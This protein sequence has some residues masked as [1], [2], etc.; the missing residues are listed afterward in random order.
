MKLIEQIVPE[1]GKKI[2]HTPEQKDVPFEQTIK[3]D[4]KIP[5]KI[6]IVTEGQFSRLINENVGEDTT[7]K[8]ESISGYLSDRKELAKKMGELMEKN[9][10]NSIT[11][12]TEI[13][14][15]EWVSIVDNENPDLFNSYIEE[16]E[17][18]E[19]GEVEFKK[20]VHD[21]D[22]ILINGKE[23]IVDMSNLDNYRFINDYERELQ[24]EAIK[25]YNKYYTPSP[26]EEGIEYDNM[27]G[28]RKFGSDYHQNSGGGYEDDRNLDESIKRNFKRF[29]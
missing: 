29:I 1:P 12:N 15:S 2:V 21:G 20:I 26:S 5:K 24:P 16:L 23:Y 27:D 25:F 18:S 22:T 9:N 11:I 8:E 28:N 19:N 6:I 10:V 4:T 13:P 3:S 17:T 14:A 7:E